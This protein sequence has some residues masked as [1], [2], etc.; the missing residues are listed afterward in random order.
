M[1][2]SSFLPD[3]LFRLRGVRPPRSTMAWT[4]VVAIAIPALTSACRNEQV[5]EPLPTL[6][7]SAL[8]LPGPSAEPNG[9]P[10]KAAREL[11]RTLNTAAPN[12]RTATLLAA[13]PWM[14]L[15]VTDK[16]GAQVATPSQD[17]SQGLYLPAWQ[18]ITLAT[19]A[20]NQIEMPFTDFVRVALAEIP[21]AEPSQL[22]QGLV[23]DVARATKSETEI[24]ARWAWMIVQSGRS[25]PHPHDLLE[26][27]IRAQD[28]KLTALQTTLMFLR[29]A[30]ESA[31][32]QHNQSAKNGRQ[33]SLTAQAAPPQRH[34]CSPIGSDATVFD[35]A[36]AGLSTWFGAFH[37]WVGEQLPGA[38]GYARALPFISAGLAAVQLAMATSS[39][40]VL[41]ELRPTPLVRTK[42]T[43]PGEVGEAAVAV[44]LASSDLELFNCA[45]IFLIF[46]GTDFSIS[47]GGPVPNSRMTVVQEGEKLLEFPIQG[48]HLINRHTDQRGRV[49]ATVRGRRQDNDLPS[50]AGPVQK[51]ERWRIEV[52]Y[53]PNDLLKDIRDVGLG[54]TG[55]LA[56]A[57][58]P[59]LFKTVAAATIFTTWT[60]YL[61]VQDW[62]QPWPTEIIGSIDSR[63]LDRRG[64]FAFTAHQVDGQCETE[65]SCLYSMNPTGSFN[66]IVG[67]NR[68]EREL[69]GPPWY[70]GIPNENTIQ[71]CA[72]GADACGKGKP[73]DWPDAGSADK[74]LLRV[75]VS[76]YSLATINGGRPFYWTRLTTTRWAPGEQ[77]FDG[78]IPGDADAG[79]NPKLTGK[80]NLQFRYAQ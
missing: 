1:R 66:W 72:P 23:D 19:A 77:V 4:M 62:K 76:V 47:P 79:N 28:V 78:R 39:L 60:A 68:Q 16:A 73:L 65:T 20:Q 11:V 38:A 75:V 30:G 7:R 56:G 3:G 18:T 48:Q 6:S 42:T 37:S 25:A 67:S 29:L 31:S 69:A 52:A 9:S 50:T 14:G 44:R 53:Q 8:A 64:E 24:E 49:S 55:G 74:Y 13:L 32:H 40:E 43:I 26:A 70:E 51:Q 57:V 21:E 71:I 10:E 22:A 59:L 61:P 45:R 63:A 36:A 33:T 80:M 5:P 15:A 2:R 54:G 12:V 58:V 41:A 34:P 27:G 46:L 35:W 17:A